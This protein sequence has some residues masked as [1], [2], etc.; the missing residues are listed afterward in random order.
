VAADGG[1]VG[2]SAGL[3]AVA[4]LALTAHRG[5]RTALLGALAGAAVV[6]TADTVA[7]T[8]QQ[9]DEIPAWWSRL[10]GS[11]AVA[12]PLG[13]VA[14]RVTG[15]GPTVVGTATGAVA[16]ALGLRPEKVALGPVVGFAVGRALATHDPQP[17]AS[18]VAATTV[19]VFRSLSALAF[20][21][22]QVSLL[23]DQVSPD[24]LPFVVPLVA[25][26]RYVGTGYVRALSER[27]GGTY[28]EAAPDV[29]IVESLDALAGPGF[30]PAS[31]HRLVREFYE[32][33]T[34]FVLD[35]DPEWRMWVRPGYLLY[36]TVVAR[37]L[38]QASVPMNQREAQRGVHSRIDTVTPADDGPV[39][40]G[41]IRSFADTDEPIYVGIYTTYRRRGRGYVSVGFPLPQASF[42]ATL[43]PLARADGGLTLTSRGRTEDSGHYL[44]YVDPESG[45]LTALSLPGFA[46]RLDVYVRDG[47]LRAEHAFW[48]FGFPFLVLHY[49]ITRKGEGDGPT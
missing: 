30:D 22:E 43:E 38:G 31:V 33:T 21:E 20:R 26:T 8:R 19:G 42:T 11:V 16:G 10:I 1:S 14:A 47:E 35:I 18:V 40:R 46:E 23:A 12:A 6:G 32:H 5:R 45:D 48:V 41:W 34:R 39:V 17:P 29:G 49:R 3:G 28:T 7:R 4:G 2:F 27:T 9:P 44:T 25:R 15:A 37:P 24:R 36:R 13:W